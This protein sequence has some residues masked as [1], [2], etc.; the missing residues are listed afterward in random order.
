MKDLQL[1]SGGWGIGWAGGYGFKLSN[2]LGFLA[3]GPLFHIQ[4]GRRIYVKVKNVSA[5][6]MGIW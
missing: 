1:G 5:F 6:V 2:Y 4:I 3:I